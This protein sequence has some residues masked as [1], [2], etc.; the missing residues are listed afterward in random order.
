M[1]N[2]MEIDMK[3][4]LDAKTVI[5]RVLVLKTSLGQFGPKRLIKPSVQN[6]GSNF[7]KQDIIF[8]RIIS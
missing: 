5:F 2:I 6:S 1:Q 3:K 7:H 4:I 8:S